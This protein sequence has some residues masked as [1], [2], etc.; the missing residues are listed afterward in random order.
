MLIEFVLLALGIL[1]LWWGSELAIGGAKNIAK[2]FRISAGF[3]GLSI[4]SIGTSVPEIAT[5]V[6]G[7]IQRSM[8]IETSGIVVGNAIGSAVNLLTLIL[9]IVGLIGILAIKKRSLFREGVMLIGSLL[10]IGFMSLDGFLSP[11]EGWIMVT[12]YVLYMIDLMRQEKVVDKVVG[13]R[14]SGSRP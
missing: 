6:T 14:P 9:G 10:L 3:I 2:H 7:G 8:G 1:G 12:I 11:A 13:R 5:S 4:L